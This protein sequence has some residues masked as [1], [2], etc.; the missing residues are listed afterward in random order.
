LALPIRQCGKSA[1]LLLMDDL[2]LLAENGQTT[3]LGIEPA[4]RE[5]CGI[6]SASMNAVPRPDG[7]SLVETQLISGG[8]YDLQTDKAPQ[9]LFLI[10]SQVY[11]LHEMPFLEPPRNACRL[12]RD[13]SV[14]GSDGISCTYH[15]VAPTSGLR[16]AETFKVRD[17]SWTEFRKSG[18]VEFDP[19]FRGLTNL[20]TAK[21]ADLNNPL[22]PPH[23]PPAKTKKDAKGSGDDSANQPTPIYTLSGTDLH[24]IRHWNCGN[25]GALRCTPASTVTP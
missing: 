6:R 1:N 2:K 16:S 20:V 17:L 12:V 24:K 25:R 21:A 18:T 11:G 14:R 9:P 10:G 5:A 15:F 8:A 19:A 22:A 3:T 23:A 4:N 13:G 7:T